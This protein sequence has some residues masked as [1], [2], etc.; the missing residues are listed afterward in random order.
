MIANPLFA[1]VLSRIHKILSN[2]I[3]LSKFLTGSVV[4]FSLWINLGMLKKMIAE[5]KNNT[6]L[7]SECLAY[8][9][10]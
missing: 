5:M 7:K 8:Q 3:I 6:C 1:G 10:K 9:G 2:F 4:W